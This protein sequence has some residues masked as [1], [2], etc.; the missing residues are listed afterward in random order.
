MI[1][2]VLIA[3][4][5]MLLLAPVP[6][7]QAFGPFVGGYFGVSSARSR[8]GY[9]LVKGALFGVLLGLLALLVSAAVAV[10]LMLTVDL[11]LALLWLAVGVFTL[12]TGNLGA[13]GAIY[14]L[15]GTQRRA[16]LAQ[17]DAFLD[18]G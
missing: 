8:E 14:R 9:C 7:A 4:G 16:R 3:F 17:E 5:I 6:L 11:N 2:G 12:Y 10:A 18:T 1:R 13:L 15:L